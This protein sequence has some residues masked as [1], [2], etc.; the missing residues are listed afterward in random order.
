LKKLVLAIVAIL[1]LSGC[2]SEDRAKKTAEE[3]MD[4]VKQGDEYAGL[5]AEEGFID[6]FNYEYLQTLDEYQEKDTR[7]LTYDLWDSI[8]G[9][10]P[11]AL[12]PT[13]EDYKKA[14]F[15]SIEI[16]QESKDTKYEI[17]QD[18]SQTL[19]YWDGESYYDVYTFLYNVEIANE[20]GQKVYKKAEITVEEGLV[21]D[22][23]KDEYVDGFVI[24]E[25]YI[26]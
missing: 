7:E 6:V 15:E 18:D 12:Y 25:V 13:F 4:A 24:A 10:D 9:D 23:K 1:F 26:R 5:E 19:E 8:Y 16:M 3:Y 20:A 17:L 11:D 22:K 2:G 21:K 14:E